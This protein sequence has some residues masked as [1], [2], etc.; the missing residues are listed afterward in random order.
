[1]TRKPPE[2]PPAKR[3]PVNSPST[4]RA[5]RK[6]CEEEQDPTT[7]AAT[8]RILKQRLPPTMSEE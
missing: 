4:S 6:A 3:V 1:M 5:K 8:L 7:A 2:Q